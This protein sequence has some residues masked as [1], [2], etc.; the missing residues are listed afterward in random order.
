MSKTAI[1]EKNWNV[2]G[3]CIGTTCLNVDHSDTKNTHLKHKLYIWVKKH[4]IKLNQCRCQHCSTKTH[5]TASSYRSWRHS[6]LASKSMTFDA[7]AIALNCI[8]FQSDAGGSQWRFILHVQPKIVRRFSV[9]SSFCSVLLA[10]A[11]ICVVQ[12]SKCSS[13]CKRRITN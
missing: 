12:T 6:T 10:S 8:K 2:F 11:T 9:S 1:H 3:N 13:M 7:Y 5:T 4:W